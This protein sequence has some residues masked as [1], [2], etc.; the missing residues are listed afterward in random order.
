MLMR[1][2]ATA[3]SSNLNRRLLPLYV[4]AV[5]QGLILWVPVEKLLMTEIGFDP[6]S[7]GVMA[8]AY[9]ALV[10]MVELPSGILADRWSRR[11]VLVISSL[12]LAVCALV[13]GLSYDVPTYIASA[14]VLGVYFAMYSGTMDSVVYDTV[15]EETGGS[16][17]FERY[18]GRIRLV[19]SIALVLSAL[20]GGWL[21]ELVSTRFTYFATVPFAAA[22]VLALL[23]FRE[24]QLHKSAVRTSLTSHIAVTY[25]TVL[26]TRGLLP[27]VGQLVL[28]SLLM[29]TVFEFGPL[30][31]IALAAGPV[32]FG[33]FTAGLTATLGIGGL[34]AGRIKLDHPAVLATVAGLMALCG[35]TLTFTG[36][37]LVV[38]VAQ[39]VLVSLAVALSI[40]L[41]R[42]LHDAVP[43]SVRSGVASG[44]GAVSWLVFLPFALVFGVV[45]RD[46]GVHAAG[47]LLVAAIAVTGLLLGRVARRSAVPTQA[48]EVTA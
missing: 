38:T 15:L 45:S 29:I 11:G 40:Y 47:W 48:A 22:S 12:A 14:L 7:I 42:L 4:A 37:I 5:L 36:S 13:G 39:V 34:L 41:T 2:P 35:L 3:K 23:A 1:A 28:T 21:A 33:P 17:D 27:V 46:A 10:P 6:A 32:V 9:A 30:W 31:L 18:S 19:N 25:R 20:A 24:P 16:A 43:S 26:R 44:V 8:A